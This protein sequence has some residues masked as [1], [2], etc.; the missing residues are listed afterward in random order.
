L[1]FAATVLNVTSDQVRGLIDDG[2]LL[3]A[4]DLS[5]KQTRPLIRIWAQSI[6]DYVS[7]TAPPKHLPSLAD[8]LDQIFPNHGA[9]ILANEISRRAGCDPE[10]VTNLWRAGLLRKAS[11]SGCRSGRNGSPLIDFASLTEFFQER[12]L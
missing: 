7:Q 3:F 6:L 1:D 10:H 11:G 4:W 12:Q 9:K 5:V 8:V 2:R